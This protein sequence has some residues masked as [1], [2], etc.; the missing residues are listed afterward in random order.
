LF[1]PHVPALFLTFS[2]QRANM[3]LLP[4]G[5]ACHLQLSN[6]AVRSRRHA[7]P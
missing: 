4:V 5:A 2:E 1:S 7:D 6:A 3:L